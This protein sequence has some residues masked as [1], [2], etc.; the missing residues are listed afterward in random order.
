[1][2]AGA[3][4]AG[5]S[6]ARAEDGERQSVATET[7]TQALWPA[8]TAGG[9]GEVVFAGGD[10]AVGGRLEG[11]GEVLGPVEV[12][13]VPDGLGAPVVDVVD[14]PPPDVP[15][16]PPQAATT[17]RAAATAAPVRPRTEPA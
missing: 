15:L 10:V 8:R 7:E 17:S 3:R 6:T 16:G 2:S 4:R 9:A 11:D 12:D 1:M 13:E 14:E 5:A